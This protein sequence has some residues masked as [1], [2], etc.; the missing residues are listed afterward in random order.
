MSNGARSTR[1]ADSSALGNFTAIRAYLRSSICKIFSVFF[2]VA[3][4]AECCSVSNI[5]SQF[6]K[7]CPRLNM[8]GV[9]FATI[10]ASNASVSIAGKDGHRPFPT[11]WHEASFLVMK[12]L[13][14]LPIRAIFTY[15]GFASTRARTKTRLAVARIKLFITIFTKTFWQRITSCPTLFTTKFRLDCSIG[16]CPIRITTNSTKQIYPFPP[17][18]IWDTFYRHV[19]NYSILIQSIKNN[20][21]YCDV[22]VERWEKYTGK[23][24]KRK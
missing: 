15:M 1:T 18:E 24:A 8:M 2:P 4:F 7:I 3:I 20:K 16:M 9:K 6:G 10:P 11:L 12:R 22:V 17:L 21:I 13:S 19:C 5:K 23:K 14:T